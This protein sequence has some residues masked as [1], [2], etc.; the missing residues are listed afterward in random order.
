LPK[1]HEDIKGDLKGA[2]GLTYLWKHPITYYFRDGKALYGS[3]FYGE[4]I[5]HRA[6]WKAAFGRNCFL[7]SQK[8]ASWW[9]RGKGTGGTK[10][11]SKGANALHFIER[12]SV[13]ERV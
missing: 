2:V 10:P 5:T 4:S 9:K 11:A 1:A 13:A 7:S 12:S 3:L 6:Q 8:N